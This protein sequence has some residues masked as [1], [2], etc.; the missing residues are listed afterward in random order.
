MGTSS[1]GPGAPASAGKPSLSRLVDVA[2]IGAG[3]AG[4]AMAARLGQLGVRDV[5]LVDKADF[6]REKTCGS[7]VSPKGIKV[8][9]E[10]GVWSRVEPSSYWIRG[11]RLVTPGG[12]EAMLSA[13]DVQA[14]V[15]PRRVLDHHLLQAAVER[16]TQFIPY[17]NA[18]RLT[19]DGGRT[20]GFV[21]RDGRVVRA[22]HT[23][24]AGGSHCRFGGP[25]RP[26]KRVIQAIMGF[27][28]NVPFT[29]NTVEMIYDR[30]LLPYYG[31][32][33]PEG[34]GTVNIGI[35]YEERPGEKRNA[36]ALFAAFLER[37]Y[38]R[39]IAN[40]EQLGDFKGHPITWSYAIEE[41][42]APGRVV[43]GESGLLTH[44]ATAEGIYQGMRSGLLAADAIASVLSGECSEA[45]AHRAYERSV[46]RA[47]RPSFLAAGA[48]RHL[49]KTP[50]MDAVVGLTEQPALKR[51]GARILASL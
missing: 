42:T 9:Q 45:A 33:F 10:L 5:V 44:P 1:K 26:T 23:I 49:L 41:L 13:G 38:A 3:P 6:P 48:F 25:V 39:R 22:K 47:F 15:C 46:R 30:E 36:R 29:P 40:A 28:Q 16:G 27:W 19:E 50:F 32:L 2:I 17:F 8:L 18:A 20:T 31:W 43:I 51:A 34:E 11:L 12:R 37:H 4:T 7:G 14:V 24:V 35:T 21:G